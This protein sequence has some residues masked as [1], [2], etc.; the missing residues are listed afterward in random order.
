MEDTFTMKDVEEMQL[1]TPE[2][3]TAP[4]EPSREADTKT[5]PS[6]S[7]SFID[8]FK[9]AKSGE[10][11]KEEP[12]AK[13]VDPPAE[14]ESRSAKDFKQL[15][16]ER[17]LLKR[18]LSEM[19]AKLSDLKDNNVDEALE[20]LK[21]ERDSL[22]DKLKQA[23]I[24]K[25]PEFVERFEGKIKQIIETAKATVGE[26]NEERIVRL[27]NME[28]SDLRNDGMDAIFDELSPTRRHTLGAMLA[29]IDSIKVERAAVLADQQQA[30]S[31]LNSK[32]DADQ[33]RRLDESNRAFDT[34]VSEAMGNLEVFKKKDGDADWNADIDRMVGNA[35]ALYSGSDDGSETTME[36]MARATLWAAAAPRYRAL[37]GEALAENQ[38]LRDQISGNQNANPSLSSSP[39]GEAGGEPK[40]FEQIFSE[41]SGF[42]VSK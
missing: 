2:V 38:K 27:L 36:E 1:E 26:H 18:Q 25:H 6:E 23:A 16:E 15:K 32:Y 12:E 22:S 24:E 40:S 39:S 41:V 9:D 33:A 30:I 5:E 20:K 11:K 42:D 4:E 3:S 10:E 7:T 21:L 13:E 14:D 35:K 31:Q 34:A 17:E 37:L 8:K 19:E 29:Q 28:E